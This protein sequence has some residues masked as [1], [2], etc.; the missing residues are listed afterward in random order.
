MSTFREF[1]QG[2]EQGEVQ[3]VQRQQAD[4]LA[5]KL[6]E[7]SQPQA[8]QQAVAKLGVQSIDELIAKLEADPR[9]KQVM[10]AY[11]QVKGKVGQMEHSLQENIFGDIAS[12]VWSALKSVV[13]WAFKSVGRTLA[14]IFMPFSDKE[15]TPIDK[16]NYA[17]TLLLTVGL[18]GLLLATGAPLAVAGAALPYSATWFGIMW[19]GKNVLEPMLLGA[20][21]M[22]MAI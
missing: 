15:A 8:V 18:S 2:Q 20:E 22:G 1:L 21:K 17:G 10:A 19:F 13:S 16:I 5:A 6:K 11:K 3:Q 4:Q 9:V 14:H 7:I 12:G